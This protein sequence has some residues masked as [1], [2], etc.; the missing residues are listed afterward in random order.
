[1]T[2]YLMMTMT[3]FIG[4]RWPESRKYVNRKGVAAGNGGGGLSKESPPPCLDAILLMI[5]CAKQAG[6]SLPRAPYR[7]FL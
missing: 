2:S 6:I 1:M 3:T 5:V 7:H 4:L